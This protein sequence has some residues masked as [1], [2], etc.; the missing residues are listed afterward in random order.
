MNWILFVCFF[1]Q[2]K[3]QEAIEYE[4][5][6]NE[7]GPKTIALNL[8]KSDRYIESNLAEYFIKSNIINVTVREVVQKYSGTWNQSCLCV[9]CDIVNIT[10]LYSFKVWTTYYIVMVWD[11]VIGLINKL[12]LL[13]HVSTSVCCK[14]HRY[15]LG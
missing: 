2:V 13:G 10:I 1:S 4:D 9:S 3:L 11:M 14:R 8:K 7:P 12:H 15:T 6:E 5:L